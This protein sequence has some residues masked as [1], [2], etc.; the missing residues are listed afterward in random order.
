MSWISATDPLVLLAIQ[1]GQINTPA[2]NK[3]DVRVYS[4]NELESAQRFIKLGEPVPIVFARFRNNKGGILV[5][6]GASEAAYFNNPYNTRKAHYHL[7]V[8]EGLISSIPVKDV[9]HGACR[10]GMHTQT[11]DRRAGTWPPGNYFLQRYDLT[12]PFNPVPYDLPEAPYFCGSVGLYPNISTV[13]FIS[14]YYPDGSDRYKR[15]VHLFIRGGMHVTRLYDN[16]YGPSDNF[17]DLT[18]WLLTNTARTPSALIDNTALLAAATFLEY[19]S[20]TCNCELTTSTNYAD[21]IAKWAPYFLLGESNDGGKKGLRPLLPTTAAGAINVGAITPEFTFTEDYILPGT[22]EIDYTSLAD[23]LPFVAQVVW[24]QQIE[25]DIG[26]IRTAEVRYNGTA[27]AGP[28]E[29][30][31]LSEFCTNENHA[32]KVGAYILAKRTYPTHVIR[33]STR[34]QAYNVSV[35]VGDIIAVNLQRQ[36]TNYIASAHHYLYQV[37]RVTKTLAGDLTYEAVH[38]PVDDQ[39]RSLIALDVAAA[40]GSG[41]IIPSTRT[42]VDCDE[43]S[44]TNNTIPAEQFIEPGDANDPTD[45]SG[46]GTSTGA[47]AEVTIDRG[48]N[49]GGGPRESTPSGPGS[50]NNDDPLDNDRPPVLGR[51]PNNNGLVGL[52]LTVGTPCS[53]QWLRDGSPISGA[54]S[55]TYTPT[56][57]DLGKTL[58]PQV[59]CPGSAPQLLDPIPVLMVMPQSPTGAAQTVTVTVQYDSINLGYDCTTGLP[60]FVNDPAAGSKTYTNTTCKRVSVYTL[61]TSGEYL[62]PTITYILPCNDQASRRRNGAAVFTSAANVDTVDSFVGWAGNITSNDRKTLFHTSYISSIQSNGQ[63]VLDLWLLAAV[64]NGAIYWTNGGTVT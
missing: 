43:N 54:T 36:A 55:N 45:S 63:E 17:A 18:K 2:G 47:G 51:D 27:E 20:F 30:H 31:D 8:S 61:G 41:L 25:S 44:S 56:G 16:V 24:R 1:A 6:P 14:P 23:R 40:T 48:G 15:Q 7:P 32:V 62:S 9:F 46:T 34:P 19:N 13:S 22:L 50:P 4:S 58:T 26:I 57:D 49:S 29:T 28:Y 12:D 5:S 35:T 52:P 42:G 33:F 39:N 10:V 38:F 11:Y 59:T 3:K 60:T 37:E 21:F 53:V 64:D